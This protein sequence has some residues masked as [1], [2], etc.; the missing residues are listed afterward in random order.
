MAEQS[1]PAQMLLMRCSLITTAEKSPYA[2]TSI[3]FAP[4]IRTRTMTTLEYVFDICL[5]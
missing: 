5:L 4:A 3:M 2:P 1:T